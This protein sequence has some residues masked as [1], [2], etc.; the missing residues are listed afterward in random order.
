MSRIPWAKIAA[1]GVVL[2]RAHSVLMQYSDGYKK[3][4]EFGVDQIKRKLKLRRSLLDL[5]KE[6]V[7]EPSVGQYTFSIPTWLH[8][9]WLMCDIYDNIEIEKIHCLDYESIKTLADIDRPTLDKLDAVINPGISFNEDNKVYHT[10]FNC[11]LIP[12]ELLGP[13]EKSRILPNFYANLVLA[14]KDN[15]KF[16]FLIFRPA[17]QNG[18]QIQFNYAKLNISILFYEEEREQVMNLWNT[19]RNRVCSTN[20]LRKKIAYFWK[21]ADEDPYLHIDDEATLKYRYKKN[22]I[23]YSVFTDEI[24]GMLDDIRNFS[25]KQIKMTDR[26]L[27][28]RRSY[29][30]A[31]PPGT[32]KTQ[33]IRALL[34]ILPDI[35]TIVNVSPDYISALDRLHYYEFSYVNFP[36]IIIEDI[37]L[38]LENDKE[39]QHLLNFLDGINSPKNLITIM[40][41]NRP[42]LLADN[43]IR[44]PGRVDRICEV[45]PGNAKIREAQL[46]L[47]TKGLEFSSAMVAKRTEG[48]SF[49]HLRELVRRAEILSV[50]DGIE[51]DALEKSLEECK[52]QFAHEFTEW[53]TSSIH[54]VNEEQAFFAKTDSRKC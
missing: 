48:F 54:W 3:T 17:K 9:D 28:G 36:V 27:D 44:R 11:E 43:L 46:N 39:K 51:L 18:P 7:N 32:G 31:G 21:V 13:E 23:D 22:E 8:I 14:K 41:T 20:V 6:H 29:L 5:I 34:S 19:I 15:L 1:A 26:G 42:N 40:T 2:E 30:M 47:L 16:A 24:L 53:K 37:D 52:R 33:I 50:S 12:E 35:Y 4:I 10:S 49:S 25:T 38:I 45:L